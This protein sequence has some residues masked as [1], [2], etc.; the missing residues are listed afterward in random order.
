MALPTFNGWNIVAMPN[1]KFRGVDFSPHDTVGVSVSDWTNEMQVYDWQS[2]FLSANVTI[3]TQKGALAAQWIAFLLA[4]RGPLNVFILGDS[5]Q[6]SPF[7]T[8]AVNLAPD[9]NFQMPLGLIW[10]QPDANWWISPTSK[11]GVCAL[12]VAS[13]DSGLDMGSF[14]ANV[15]VVPG[16]SYTLSGYI[17]ASG[18]TGGTVKLLVTYTGGNFVLTAN[19]GTVANYS[20][21]FTV[22]SGITS[23]QIECFCNNAVIPSGAFVGF[24]GISLTAGAPIVNGAAQVGYSLV[25]NG[26][27]PS[28]SNLLIAGDYITVMSSPIGGGDISIPRLYRLTQPVSSDASGNATLSIWPQLRESPASAAQ[29]ITTNTSGLFRLAP[30]AQAQWH[31]SYDGTTSMSF[32]ATEAL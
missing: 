28:A 24:S 10:S 9:P 14:S 7:G 29:I 17:D 23:L 19:N 26:W 3:P 11:P 20:G 32:Q 1:F 6:S 13:A 5:S 15:T 12:K 8:C 21:S 2:S 16:R 27:A 22:P 25:T 4:C 30:G 18:V 31:K